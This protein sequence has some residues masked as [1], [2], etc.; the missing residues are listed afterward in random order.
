MAKVSIKGSGFKSFKPVK[1]SKPAT[2]TSKPKTVTAQKTNT[3]GKPVETK[4][5]ATATQPAEKTTTA[6]KP[7]PAPNIVEKQIITKE[8]S[9]PQYIY[10]G[11]NSNGF[12][13][14]LSNYIVLDWIFGSRNNS[15]APAPAN[16]ASPS[17]QNPNSNTA[18]TTTTASSLPSTDSS[19]VEGNNSGS[20]PFFLAFTPLV[21]I[22]ILIP[23]DVYRYLKSRQENK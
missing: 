22:S 21:L 10:S 15:S 3:V 17:V 5:K 2:V 4:P 11:G 20:L 23:V 12:G 14:M 19:I 6:T 1:I 9:K 16:T 8:V 13:E 7:D 18:V